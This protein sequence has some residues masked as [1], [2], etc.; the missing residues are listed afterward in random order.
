ME[1]K[2]LVW[3]TYVTH[4]CAADVES[5]KGRQHHLLPLTDKLRLAGAQSVAGPADKLLGEQWDDRECE[6][7]CWST[8]AGH[9]GVLGQGYP[10][11][12][13]GPFAGRLVCKRKLCS[14]TACIKERTTALRNTIITT[15]LLPQQSLGHWA[16]VQCCS[17]CSKKLLKATF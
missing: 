14:A 13:S 16:T 1:G 12:S 8:G 10:E 3:P 2:R 17:Q 4:R 11:L 5:T 9:H 15:Q 7:V 6:C